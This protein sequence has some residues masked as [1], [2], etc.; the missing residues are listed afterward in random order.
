MLSQL[1]VHRAIPST[2]TPKQL[3]RFSW[4]VRTPTRSPLRVSQT[5]HVQSSYPPNR[6]RP[7]IENATDVMPQ[8][9]LSCVYELSSRS[10]RIS[11]RRQEASSEPVAKASPLG[12]NLWIG[13]HQSAG[14]FERFYILDCIDVRLV[15]REGLCR[16][17]ATNVPKFGRCIT[18]T[19]H[20]G[21]LVRTKRQAVAERFSDGSS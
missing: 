6:I 15:S 20:E 9:M 14:N 3:T 1:P 11:K 7:E 5:L 16:L 12:K 21:V 8:R 4:P 18:S 13:Q 19:R 17:S 2:L 10:A